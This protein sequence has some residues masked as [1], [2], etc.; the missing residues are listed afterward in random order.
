MYIAAA[1]N[2]GSLDAVIP[3]TLDQTAGILIFDNEDANVA[4]RFITRD[5]VKA[6]TDPWCEA[7]LCGVIYSPPLF[8]AIA[9]QGIT[10]YNAAGM[11]VR[12]AVAAMDAYEL[13]MI[14]D[15]FGGSGCP[16]HGHEHH[17]QETCGG[18]CDSCQQACDSR[19]T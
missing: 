4:P 8:E 3:E 9:G 16:G 13:G 5:I 17:P 6:M 7:L 15:Y 19:E 18:Q 14:T 12:E 10:R 11:T 1:V 2:E